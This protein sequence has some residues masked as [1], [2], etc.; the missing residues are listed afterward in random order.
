MSAKT[1][2]KP[3]VQLSGTDGNAF[4]II[5]RCTSALEKSHPRDLVEEF[6]EKALAACSYDEMLQVCMTYCDVR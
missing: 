6:Q 1:V 5:G 3:K 2:E 4:F